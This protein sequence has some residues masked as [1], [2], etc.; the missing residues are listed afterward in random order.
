V[1]QINAIIIHCSATHDGMDIGAKEIKRWHTDPKPKGNG[2]ADIGY[3][4]VIR[5]NG[6]VE[7]GRP[8][9][10]VGAHVSNH[11]SD[12]IGICLVGGI[13]RSGKTENNFT[14]PQW[15]SLERLVRSLKVMYPKATVHGHREFAA[16]DC[17]SFDV[18]AWIKERG[19]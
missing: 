2:W 6:L 3:H 10:Q 16:K 14:A 15:S 11:N 9:E 19:I 4:H 17:P 12:S 7:M 1:R 5:R 18:Q 8:E 13:D